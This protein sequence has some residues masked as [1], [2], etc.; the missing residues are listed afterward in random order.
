MGE[1]LYRISVLIFY[2]TLASC[3]NALHHGVLS[4]KRADFAAFFTSLIEMKKPRGSPAGAATRHG[5]GAWFQKAFK[6][7]RFFERGASRLNVSG[8]SMCGTPVRVG[9]GG[10][11]RRRTPDTDVK[12]ILY[13]SL[14]AFAVLHREFL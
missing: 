14:L 12:G 7:G 13:A 1:C 9:R 5:K 10:G 4:V 8:L 3:L 2:L 6:G 11:E